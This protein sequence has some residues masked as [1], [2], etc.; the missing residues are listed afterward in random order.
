MVLCRPARGPD[1]SAIRAAREAFHGL[2]DFTR[3]AHANR[4]DLDL[5]RGRHGLNDGKLA[6]AGSQDSVTKHYSPRQ[7]RRNLLQQF[8]PFP[9]E[10]KFELGKTGDIAL[11]PRQV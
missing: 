9:A 6:R 4:G 3:I 10:T 8:Q 7:S 11:W 1:Q 2:L 5:E